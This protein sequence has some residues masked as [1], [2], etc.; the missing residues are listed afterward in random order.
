MKDTYT[1]NIYETKLQGSKKNT[2]II[3]FKQTLAQPT[4]SAA[5]MI[6]VS[7]LSGENFNLNR[8]LGGTISRWDLGLKCWD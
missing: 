2:H 4:S 3:S 8:D 6:M 7:T 5:W 1:P